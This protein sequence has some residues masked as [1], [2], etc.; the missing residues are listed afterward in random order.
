TSESAVLSVPRTR[1]ADLS[2][3]KCALNSLASKKEPNTSHLSLRRPSSG[4]VL[5]VS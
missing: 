2:V 3:R 4:A 5:P 1:A